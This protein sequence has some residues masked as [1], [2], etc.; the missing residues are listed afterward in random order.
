V[1]TWLNSEINLSDTGARLP[2]STQTF[3]RIFAASHATLSTVSVM[4]F[5]G[6]TP[7][8]HKASSER[9]HPIQASPVRAVFLNP[10]IVI[11]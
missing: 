9:Y 4:A 6:P 2:I 5:A 3:C 10:L 7:D 1:N 8:S 11:Y